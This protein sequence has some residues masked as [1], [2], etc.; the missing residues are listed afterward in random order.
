MREILD[1]VSSAAEKHASIGGMINTGLDKLPGM[2][3]S[4]GSTLMTDR[5]FAGMDLAGRVH[6]RLSGAGFNT[7]KGIERVGG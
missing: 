3:K 5:G 7:I 1:I 4:I 2:A 6:T